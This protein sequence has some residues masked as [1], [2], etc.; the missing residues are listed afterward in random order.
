M[1]RWIPSSCTSVTQPGFQ[2][3]HGY[4]KEYDDKEGTSFMFATKMKMML[5]KNSDLSRSPETDCGWCS[6]K[7]V[8]EKETLESMLE[9]C[10]FGQVPP[11]TK[12]SHFFLKR[13]I[14]STTNHLFRRPCSIR[15]SCPLSAPNTHNQRGLRSIKKVMSKSTWKKTFLT[16]CDCL[17]YR[18]TGK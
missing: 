14:F 12:A 5:L 17:M 2:D 13:I 16:I 4:D 18:K 9:H 3:N 11:F 1:W 6:S 15:R 7:S 8:R 10:L